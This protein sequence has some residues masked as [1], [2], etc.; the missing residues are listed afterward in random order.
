MATEGDLPMDDIAQTFARCFRG[1]D[2]ARAIA[3]LRA[4]TLEC[5]A[6]PDIADGRLRHL[7]GQRFM[8]RTIINLIERGQS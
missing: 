1:T 3:H 8:V 2:G 6:G 7:E 4:T 5:A